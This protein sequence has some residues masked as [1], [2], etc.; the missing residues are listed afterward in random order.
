MAT[1]NC[2]VQGGRFEITNIGQVVTAINEQTNS[3]KTTE[4]I[5]P[6][7]FCNWA[8]PEWGDS[9][10]SFEK[11]LYNLA[12][13]AVATLNTLAQ[14]EIADKQYSLAKDYLNLSK[15]RRNRFR[16]AYGPFEQQMLQETFAVPIFVANYSQ[17]QT[18]GA[19]NAR[20]AFTEANERLTEFAKQYNL[21][22][23]E[24]LINDLQNCGGIASDDGV[25]FNYRDEENYAILKNDQRWNRRLNLL[26]L[27][28]DLHAQ[29]ASYA[30]AANQTL[31]GLSNLANE[32]TQGAIGLLGYLYE[33][34]ETQYP[35]TF[36][37]ATGLSGNSGYGL[38]GSLWSG[39]QLGPSASTI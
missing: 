23:S 25:N 32:G 11:D 29:S 31:A 37:G 19:S 2:Y 39:A 35:S 16:D 36:S 15:D 12:L 33:R 27:G 17:A 4:G 38:L 30:Q 24:S 22:F 3:L 9:G 6:I 7:R 26:N 28:R 20:E 14:I 1:C 34:R 8:A 13:V 18:D 21:C 5:A 10:D